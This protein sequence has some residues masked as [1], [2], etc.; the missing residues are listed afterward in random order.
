MGQ[1]V[2]MQPTAT[3]TDVPE[4]AAAD[5]ASGPPPSPAT[6][7][8]SGSAAAG[9]SAGAGSPGAVT[10]A[11]PAKLTLSLRITGR[12]PD[13]YHTLKAEMVSVDLCD[14]LSIDPG[15]DGLSMVDE[16]V[17][18]LRLQHADAGPDN[19]VNRAL[20]ACGRRAGVTLVKR[21][22]ARAGLG[23]GSSDA[24]AVLRWAGIDDAA[25]AVQLGADVPFCVRGGRALVQGVGEEV[26]PLPFEERHYVLLLPPLGVDTAA[27]YRAWD[28]LA[29]RWGGDDDRAEDRGGNDLER[30]A[31][32]VAPELARWRDL[33]GDMTGHRPRL[34]GSGS[35]WFVEGTPDELSLDDRPHLLVDGQRAP[36]VTVSTVPAH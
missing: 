30:P 17:G 24:G 25:V 18:G 4:R 31:L 33:L 7:T 28:N 19:L 11:A 3:G 12:R 10:M 23:G 15:G 6:L 9:P 16:V 27:C 35:T 8:S 34:A 2:G 14:E 22:P 29:G 20:R 26:T 5:S 21:I 1:T 32:L 13:G 36:L